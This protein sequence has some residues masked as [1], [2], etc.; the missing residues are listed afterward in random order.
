MRGLLARVISDDFYYALLSWKFRLAFFLYIKNC[1]KKSVSFSVKSCK[2]AKAFID[3][4]EA[5]WTLTDINL[6]YLKNNRWIR[7]LFVRFEW[8][9]LS[10]AY[11]FPLPEDLLDCCG[12]SFHASRIYDRRNSFK[13]MHRRFAFNSS[14]SYSFYFNLPY[15][16]IF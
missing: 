16:T 4:I 8:I 5:G 1:K 9:P 7:V 13:R 15:I 10:F 2:I 6:V 3:S 12:C 14:L 11:V